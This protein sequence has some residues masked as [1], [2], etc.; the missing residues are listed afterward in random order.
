MAVWYIVLQIIVKTDI[1]SKEYKDVEKNQI[2]RY[3]A[4]RN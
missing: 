2:I 1:T 3:N 4:I